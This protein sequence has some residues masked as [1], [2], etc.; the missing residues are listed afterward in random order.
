MWNWYKVIKKAPRERGGPLVRNTQTAT[1][2][3]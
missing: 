3:S 1:V 2:G